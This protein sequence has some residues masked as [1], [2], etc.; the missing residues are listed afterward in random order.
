[1]IKSKGTFNF[2]ITQSV[3]M[4]GLDDSVYQKSST[5]PLSGNGQKFAMNRT[6]FDGISDRKR[7][8]NRCAAIRYRGRH[9]C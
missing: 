7:E 6:H 8:Q 2:Q 4:K 3:A 5:V 9:K 1:M